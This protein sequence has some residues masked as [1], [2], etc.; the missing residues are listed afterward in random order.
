ML[1]EM[2]HDLLRFFGLDA[3]LTRVPES[4]WR[5]FKAEY[6][7][8]SNFFISNQIR[9]RNN[10]EIVMFTWKYWLDQPNH[11]DLTEE[12]AKELLQDLKKNRGEVQLA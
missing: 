8:S 3:P 7:E 12:C 2:Y 5:A 6:P 9:K 10:L 1:R 11:Y 4:V